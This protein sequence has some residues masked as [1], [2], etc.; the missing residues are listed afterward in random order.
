[1]YLFLDLDWISTVLIGGL[2]LP[3]CKPEREDDSVSIHSINFESL[4]F[5]NI[6]PSKTWFYSSKYAVKLRKKVLEMQEIFHKNSPCNVVHGEEFTFIGARS[7]PHCILSLQNSVG[8]TQEYAEYVSFLRKGTDEDMIVF[9]MRK[10]DLH[11]L[12]NSLSNFSAK[13]SETFT[14]FIGNYGR[15]PIVHKI[16]ADNNYGDEQSACTLFQML[17]FEEILTCHVISSLQKENT[18]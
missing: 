18:I 16:H 9:H 3:Y 12:T 5:N 13:F 4:L 15:D 1:M 11:Y 2:L 6:G 10:D 8:F 14:E 17:D 7:H